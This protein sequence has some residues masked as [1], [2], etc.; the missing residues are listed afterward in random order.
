MLIPK[1]VVAAFSKLKVED[2]Y[3]TRTSLAG[4]EV[5]RDSLGPRM[6]ATN[7]H[8]L[9]TSAF[10]ED[11]AANYPIGCGNPEHVEKFK[12]IIPMDS[13]KGIL[14]MF[15]KGRNLMPILGNVLLEEPTAN[16]TVRLVADLPPV[17]REVTAIDGDFPNWQRVVPVFKNPASVSFN[18]RYMIELCNALIASSP[19]DDGYSSGVTL[20]IENTPVQKGPFTLQRMTQKEGSNTLAVLMPLKAI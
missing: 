6:T 11:D 15:P 17:S 4:A 14:S 12:T 9:L 16:G 7:G 3:T 1:E 19:E 18:P 8:W 2:A 10:K 13:M 20:T 5:T